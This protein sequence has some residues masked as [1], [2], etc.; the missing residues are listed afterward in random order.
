MRVL[1]NLNE[2]FRRRLP[3]FLILSGI[4]AYAWYALFP[5]LQTGY[6][7]DDALNVTAQADAELKE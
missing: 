7:A 4:I 1:Y 6:F 2:S 3:D 5:L